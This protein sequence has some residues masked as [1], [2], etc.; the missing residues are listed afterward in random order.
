[1]RLEKVSL[2]IVNGLND[3]YYFGT[4]AQYYLLLFQKLVRV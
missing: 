4:C 3:E 1:M 2:R